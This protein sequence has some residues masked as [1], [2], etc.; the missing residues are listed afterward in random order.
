LKFTTCCQSR[1]EKANEHPRLMMY[2][3]YAQIV[4]E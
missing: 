3:S 4:I 1:R 2:E